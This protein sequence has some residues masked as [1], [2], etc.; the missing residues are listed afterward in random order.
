VPLF[1]PRG[2]AVI[3]SLGSGDPRIAGRADRDV[4]EAVEL[5]GDLDAVHQNGA[6]GDAA[7]ALNVG[8]GQGDS[9]SGGGNSGRAS[10]GSGN[11]D[12]GL[13]VVVGNQLDGTIL[14]LDLLLIARGRD[15]EGVDEDASFGNAAEASASRRSEECS[16]H[17]GLR[18]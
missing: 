2:V 16:G 17:N 6:S 5:L 7:H 3:Q 14:V 4:L 18:S 9:Y 1:T 12:R 13:G 11:G 10:N 8:E 15:G